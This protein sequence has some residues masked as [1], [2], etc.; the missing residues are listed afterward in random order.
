MDAPIPM[1][2]DNKK[3]VI[4]VNNDPMKDPAIPASSGCLESAFVKKKLL[5]FVCNLPV[6]TNSS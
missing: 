5:N 4:K 2:N 3:T 1:G 6:E